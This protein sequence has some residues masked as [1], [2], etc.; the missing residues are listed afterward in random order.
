[1][2]EQRNK[3]LTKF[4]LENQRELHKRVSS[5]AG[6]MYNAEDVVQEAFARALKYWDSFN[7][8]H[9]KLGAWFNTIL[10]NSLKDFKR[11]ELQYGMCLELDEGI[12]S[13]EAKQALS[14]VRID[15]V[16]A[17]IESKHGIVRD[18]LRLV[19]CR[20]YKPSEV[21]QVL[22][23]NSKFVYNVVDRFKQEVLGG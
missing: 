12:A 17:L 9:H 2:T 21:I 4:F 15:A 13:E 1:M 14:D 6:G 8:D 11:E 3:E 5:R 19:F 23:V 20:G 22:N 10:N 18:V 7:P 16:E